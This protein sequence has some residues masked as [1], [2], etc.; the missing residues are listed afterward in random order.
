MSV[1][2]KCQAVPGLVRT[3][4]DK[5]PISILKKESNL[6]EMDASGST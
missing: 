1:L 6:R 4:N 2:E 3:R 5:N